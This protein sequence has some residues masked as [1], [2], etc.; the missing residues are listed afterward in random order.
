MLTS[1]SVDANQNLTRFISHE[2]CTITF[3]DDGSH[4]LQS[5]VNP[6]GDRT[7]TR[8]VPTAGFLS[9]VQHERCQ[10]GNLYR[11]VRG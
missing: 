7:A 9:A 6:L 11:L 8:H 10:I 3:I 4:H 2:R 5:W 1:P